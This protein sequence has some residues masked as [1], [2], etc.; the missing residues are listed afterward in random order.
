M[1]TTDPDRGRLALVIGIPEFSPAARPPV[2]DLLFAT[3]RTTE[4]RQVLGS[5]LNGYQCL[6]DDADQ[7]LSGR[8]LGLRI[9]GVL[10]DEQAGD[11]LIVHILTHGRPGTTRKLYAL[12]ADG[13]SSPDTSVS[14]W[15]EIVEEFGAR[16]VLFLLDLCHAG[17][18]A[19]QEYLL[20][21]MDGRNKAWVIAASLPDE[22]A[23]NGYF[24][25]AAASVLDDI[26]RRVRQIHPSVEHVPFG[27]LV[28]WIRL[29]VYQLAENPR[30]NA[31]RQT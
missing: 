26:Q 16:R 8:E 28:D 31:L 15:L 25:Q 6:T 2:P 24:T 13:Q 1:P 12:G 30:E 20:K 9:R 3:Q 18:A 5:E 14:S 11:V 7:Q 10:E 22:K 17:N 4:L 29:A 21:K 27:T 19:R 23:F